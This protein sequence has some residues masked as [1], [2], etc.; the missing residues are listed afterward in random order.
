M[1]PFVAA[2]NFY[3]PMWRSSQLPRKRTALRKPLP[4]R[5][6]SYGF[7]LIVIR[8]VSQEVATLSGTGWH[9]AL[10]RLP[11]SSIFRSH[12][13]EINS[14]SGLRGTEDTRECI[15]RASA[16]LS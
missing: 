16:Y 11:N 13:G 2:R 4:H 5:G 14:A 10:A 9:G 1:E 6:A 12:R 8:D 15:L 7:L 3:S